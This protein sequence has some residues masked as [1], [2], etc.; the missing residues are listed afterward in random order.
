MP[1]KSAAVSPTPS[2]TLLIALHLLVLLAVEPTYL[3]PP[4]F[5]V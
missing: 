3:A 4:N 1:L 5:A 2:K